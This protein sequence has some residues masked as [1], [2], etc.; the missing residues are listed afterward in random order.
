MRLVDPR[1]RGAAERSLGSSP[2]WRVT[3][4]KSLPGAE[5]PVL[6]LMT[7][8]QDAGFLSV[9]RIA[10]AGSLVLHLARKA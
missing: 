9:E 8:L 1:C 6:L 10:V 7:A 3:V 4:R 2:R 5:R